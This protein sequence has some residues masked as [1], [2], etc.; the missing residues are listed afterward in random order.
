[1]SNIVTLQ[2]IDADPI[3]GKPARRAIRRRSRVFAALFTAAFVLALVFAVLLAAG[4]VFYDGPLLAFGPGGVR[5]APTPDEAAKLWPLTS[6]SLAQRLTGAFALLLLTAPVIF[7]FHHLRCLFALY[8]EGAVF[9]RANAG[10]IKSIGAGLIAYAIAP[11]IANRSVWLAGVTL[12]PAWFHIDEAQALVIGAL[13]FIVADVMEFG[14]EIEQERD[15]F[16]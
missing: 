12:D 3:N 9:A 1:M 5:I 7:V 2:S 8:A 6:F 16:I 15:G 11:F 10:H 13:L 14:R 4:V